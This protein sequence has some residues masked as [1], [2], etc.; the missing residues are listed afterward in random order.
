MPKF[1]QKRP[2]LTYGPKIE[3]FW[4]FWNLP[5]VFLGSNI[6][7]KLIFLLI[8]QHQYHI[9]QKSGSPVKWCQPMKFK[10]SSKCNMARKTWMMNFT[11][12]LEV[13]IDVFYKLTISFCLC[14]TRHAQKTWNKFAYICSISRKAWAIKLIFHLQINT[15]IFYKLILPP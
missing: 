4:I 1:G 12:G 10:G 6:K 15:K 3:F 2:K 7:W 8:F 14:V 5:L 11:F 9:W 13:N